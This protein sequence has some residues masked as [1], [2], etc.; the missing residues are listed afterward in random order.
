MRLAHAYVQA[1]RPSSHMPLHSC[2]QHMTTRSRKM[3]WPVDARMISEMSRAS[4]RKDVALLGPAVAQVGRL[5][6]L[7]LNLRCAPCWPR[8]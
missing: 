3:R 6:D 4:E 2:Q 7:L 5:A 8:L 1:E